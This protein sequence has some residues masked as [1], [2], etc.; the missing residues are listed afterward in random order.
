MGTDPLEDVPAAFDQ[1]PCVVVSRVIPHMDATPEG[2][3]FAAASD[4]NYLRCA[5]SPNIRLHQPTTSK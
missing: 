5:V 1:R 2:K 3:T 4:I